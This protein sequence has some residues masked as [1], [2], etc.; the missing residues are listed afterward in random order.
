MRNAPTVRYPV[1]RSV[2]Q[3]KVIGLL[4]LLGLLALLLPVMCYPSVS[5][6][7]WTVG[8]VSWFFWSVGAGYIWWRAPHGYLWWDARAMPAAGKRAGVWLWQTEGGPAVELQSL[9]WAWDVQYGLLLRAR[10]PGL[11]LPWLWL[12]AQHAP[13]WWQDLRRALTAHAGQHPHPDSL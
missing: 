1:R 7:L 2:F 3:A 13:L 8:L 10:A 12:E 11:R 9:E 6:P 4:G 5:L